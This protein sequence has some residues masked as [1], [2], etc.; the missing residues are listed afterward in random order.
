M[1]LK[2]SRF[3]FDFITLLEKKDKMVH[4]YKGRVAAFLKDVSLA[5]FSNVIDD[6]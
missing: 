4:N 2:L 5:V 1:S 6:R 3:R